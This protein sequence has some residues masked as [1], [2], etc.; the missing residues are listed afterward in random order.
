MCIFCKSESGFTKSAGD[1][2]L[3]R[4][5]EN[6]H[7]NPDIPL[8]LVCNVSSNYSYQNPGITDDTLEGKIYNKKRDLD[9]LQRMGMIPGTTMPARFILIKLL[10]MVKTSSGICGYGMKGLPAYEKARKEGMKIPGLTIE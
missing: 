9:I 4:L 6:I 1:R 3:K 2:K 7:S 5:I 8:T 10:E